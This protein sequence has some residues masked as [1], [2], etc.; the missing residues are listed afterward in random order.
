MNS[1][2]GWWNYFIQTFQ[3]TLPETFYEI[4]SISQL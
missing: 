3:T 2:Y 1:I 4:R